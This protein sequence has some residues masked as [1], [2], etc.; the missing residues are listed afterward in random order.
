MVCIILKD[1]GF[2]FH[3]H[4]SGFQTLILSLMA[5]PV[6]V[7]HNI[8]LNL[9]FL[10]YFHLMSSCIILSFLQSLASYILSRWASPDNLSTKGNTGN[11]I[12]DLYHGRE[13]NPTFLGCN[14]KLQTFRFSMICL[15]LLNVTMVTDSVLSNGGKVNPAVVIAATLQVLYAMDAMFFEEYYFYSHDYL[16]SGYG[17]SMISSY[18]TFPFLPTLITRYM[19]YRSPHVEWYYL[20]LIGCLN[21]LGYIIYRSSE[22]QRCELAKNPNNP[23]LTHLETFETIANRKLIVSGWWG[24]VRH[25]NYLGELLIQWS[26]VLPAGMFT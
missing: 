7:T 5:V 10:K 13:L 23:N 17:W 9:V 18:L 16:N 15:A 20:A 1:D 25:P 19:I 14:M 8:P 26:W 22:N 4:I 21:L 11:P 12:V 6:M 24:M 3:S 2:V